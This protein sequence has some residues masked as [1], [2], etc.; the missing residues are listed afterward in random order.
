MWPARSTVAAA[1]R[2]IAGA[3]DAPDSVTVESATPARVPSL[4]PAVAATGAARASVILASIAGAIPTLRTDAV[5]VEDV[6][7]LLAV[8]GVPYAATAN[9][10]VTLTAEDL[11]AVISVLQIVLP[12][13]LARTAAGGSTNPN[14]WPGAGSPSPWRGR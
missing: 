9:A 8:A 3:I 11:P 10:A 1:L 5:A 7:E 14:A 12:A 6:L 4:S 2:G 13:L